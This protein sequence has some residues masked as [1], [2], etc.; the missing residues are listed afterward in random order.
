V[1]GYSLTI[2][3]PCS[4]NTKVNFYGTIR[5]FVDRLNCAFLAAKIGDSVLATK[6]DLQ[7]DDADIKGDGYCATL[8]PYGSYDS[9]ASYN[10][11]FE[12]EYIWAALTSAYDTTECPFEFHGKQIVFGAVSDV[13]DHTFMYG[14]KDALLTATKTNANSKKVNRVSFK[15]G[16]NNIPW[17]YPNETENGSISLV[18]GANNKKLKKTEYLSIKN[19]S[20]LFA[21]LNPGVSVQYCKD[22]ARTISIQSN[23]LNVIGQAGVNAY[24]NWVVWD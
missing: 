12:D 17:Y 11:E 10:F 1:Q 20:Q 9:E 21:E 19:Y 3:K 5:E 18:L 4:N 6:T 2:D 13:V 14:A 8:D 7:R 22:T 16:S 23:T 24:N 15:G